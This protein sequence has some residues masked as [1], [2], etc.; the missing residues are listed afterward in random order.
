[1]RRAAAAVLLVLLLAAGLGSARLSLDVEEEVRGAQ[2]LAEMMAVLQGLETVGDEEALAR[3]QSL[4]TAHRLR[5]VQVAVRDEQSQL[6]WSSGEERVDGPLHTWPLRR[7]SGMHWT[8]SLRASEQ[9]ER[10]EAAVNLAGTLGLLVVAALA[11]LVVVRSNVNRAFQPLQGLLAAIDGVERDDPAPLRRLPTMPIAE[12]ESLAGAL[13]HLASSLEEA[14][15]RRRVLA[16]KVLT[17]QEDE[18]AHLARELHDEMGQRLTSMRVDA[19]WLV[20][21]LPEGDERRAV[22]LNLERQCEDLQVDIR[23]LLVR[24]RPLPMAVSRVSKP[25][26]DEA[27]D[28]VPE[29]ALEP[30]S[31]LV[32]LIEGLARTWSATRRHGLQVQRVQMIGSPDWTLPRPVILAV[33]RMSQEALTNVTRHAQA[34]TCRIALAM[35]CPGRLEW[36]VEDDGIG[37]EPAPSRQLERG[38]G[39]A[40]MRER[41]W[42]LG[43]ELEIVPA[44]DGPRPGL[45]LRALFQWT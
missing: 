32:D 36:S 45:R 10:S 30:V 23:Q 14:Q 2:A 33:F 24:L 12:L 7:P 44:G 5:H 31:R 15:A 11:L 16:Q 40:G 1:M 43:S 26:P 28:A 8:V 3:L 18:R 37:L 35:P 42:S 13:R 38:S 39:L 17:L 27:A 9:S 29:P 4:E 19:A 22:V 41:A 6:R 20:R 21:K 25:L 34:Q